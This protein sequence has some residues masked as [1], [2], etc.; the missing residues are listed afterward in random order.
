MHWW[1]R[2]IAAVSADEAF[3]AWRVFIGSAD[4]RAHVWMKRVGRENL[5]DASELRRMRTLHGEVNRNVLEREMKKREDRIPSLAGYLFSQ[6]AP[7]NWLTL[8]GVAH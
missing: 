1:R 4:R 3:A 5:N 7:S 6:D 8:D 2:F